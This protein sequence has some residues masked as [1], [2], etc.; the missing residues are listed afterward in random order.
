MVDF[1]NNPIFICGAPRSGTTL[2]SDLLDGHSKLLVFPNETHILQYFKAYQG[3]ARRIFFLRDYL[4]THDILFYTSRYYQE[5]FNK[6][7]TAMYGVSAAWDLSPING[8]TF[9]ETYTSFLK[10]KEISLEVVYKAMAVSLFNS[11]TS[12]GEITYPE[13]FV[14]KRPLDNEISAIILKEQFPK[15]RF[16][17]ILR[18]PRT[19]YASAKKRRIGNI[20]G[21]K[22]CPRLNG[23][24]FARGHAEISMLSFAL[25]KRN[26]ILLG[27]DYLVIRYEDLTSRP[28]EVM[29]VVADFLS[30]PWEDVLLMQTRLGKKVSSASS[31]KIALD[32]VTSLDA[33][34]MKAYN[35]LTTSLERMIVNLYNKD[36]AQEFGYD[37]GNVKPI[38]TRNIICP[39]KYEWPF[40]YFRNRLSYQKQLWHRTSTRVVSEAIHQILSKWEEGID[41]QD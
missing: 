2:L 7:L 31:F 40:H 1:V 18:D 11:Y 37:L 30:L 29:K 8:K 9:I 20:K 38:L 12:S 26:K 39:I 17:H 15:A 33:D 21:F 10:E 4:F 3:E 22:Y 41:T 34:R 36:V 28:N 5:E 23:K 16:I 24:D 19:R 35:S 27:D 13:S 6:Y 14:E 32:G 25:A